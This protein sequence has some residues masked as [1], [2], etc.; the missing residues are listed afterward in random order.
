VEGET[1]ACGTGAVAAAIV[2][3][4]TLGASGKIHTRG[5]DILSVGYAKDAVGNYARVFL[6]G[7]AV[8]VFTGEVAIDE[9]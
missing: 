9:G 7:P 4:E 6:E 2:A 3:R 8:T 1:L 5:G